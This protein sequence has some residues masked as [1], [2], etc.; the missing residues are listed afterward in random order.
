M[1][2]AAAENNPLFRCCVGGAKSIDIKKK[3]YDK[4]NNQRIW[5]DGAHR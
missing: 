4:S 2:S 3:E 1:I 5:K